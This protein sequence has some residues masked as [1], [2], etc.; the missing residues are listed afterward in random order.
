MPPCKVRVAHFSKEK[1]NF[2]EELQPCEA[3][4]VYMR[5]ALSADV[6]IEHFKRSIYS[7]CLFGAG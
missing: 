1:K 3:V 4:R 6:P 2:P 7:L 5:Q